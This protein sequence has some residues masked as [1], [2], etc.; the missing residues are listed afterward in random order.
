VDEEKAEKAIH[1]IED[2]CGSFDETGAGIAFLLPLDQV[3]GL[4]PEI[5]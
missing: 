5:S 4:K 2:V 3:F 1:I